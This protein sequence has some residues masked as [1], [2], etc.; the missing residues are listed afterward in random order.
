M[1]P[2]IDIIFLEALQLP[3]G[4]GRDRYL[5]EACGGNAGL[6]RRLEVML[7][8]DPAADAFFDGAVTEAARSAHSTLPGEKPGDEIGRFKLLQVIGEGGFGTVWMAEQSEPVQRRVALKIIRLGMDTREFV[9]RFEQE[10]QALAMMDHPNIARVLDGG[11]TPAGRPY[12]VMELVRGVPVTKFCDVHKLPVSARLEL[13]IE[14][15]HASQH[16]H[17][18]GIIHRDIKPSNVMVTLD[19]GK[20]VPKVIDFG[21]A[22]ATQGKL[23]DKTL[24]TRFEQFIGTP[25][26]MSPEQAGL[27]SYDIDTRC[28]IY[29]LGVLL[30]E[31][32]TGK[33]PFDA[34]SLASAG[35]Q[36][37]CRIIREVEPPKP[38]SRLGTIG[39]K[40]R[41]TLAA[42]RQIEPGKLNRMVEPDLDWIVMKTI[43]K[44]R[45][46]RYE[47]VNGLALD[48]RRFLSSEPVSA[49]PPSATYKFRKFARRNKAALGA[50]A[51]ID[52]VMVAATGVSLWHAGIASVAREEATATALAE[53]A[54]RVE[55]ESIT[56]FLTQVFRSP[57]PSRRG[58]DITISEVL[59]IT[60]KQMDTNLATQPARR[61]HLQTTLGE[62][63][64]GL[65]LP[66]KGIPLHETALAYYVGTF[67]RK[68]PLT[69]GVLNDLANV[70]FDAG[71]REE[72]LKLQ[73]EV[74]ALRREV[75]GPEHVETLKVMN[76][77]ANSF[78]FS[79]RE[80]EAIGLHVE[81][82]ALRRRLFGPEDPSTLSVMNNLAIS[83]MKTGRTKDALRL[84]EELLTIR[85]RILRPAHP[86]VLNAMT[87]LANC[88]AAADRRPEAIALQEEAVPL[89]R[90]VF[91]PEHSRT[92]AAMG[93]LASNYFE[94]GRQDE[95]LQLRKEVLSLCVKNGPE[96]PET[97]IAMGNLATSWS[98]AGNLEEA[99][100]LREE[101][102]KLSRKVNGEEHLDT[103]AAA[104]NLVSS[105]RETA[106]LSEAIVLQG[107]LL[108]FSR[109]VFPPGHVDLKGPLE[110]MAALYEDAGRP[111][112]AAALRREIQE[113]K[114]KYIPPPPL[115]PVASVIVAPDSEWKWLH[116]TNSK[117]PAEAVPDFH[118]TFF[119]PDFDDSAWT[120]GRDSA[121]P[122][123]GFG[124]GISFRGVSIGTPD[125][126]KY[127]R[128]AYFRHRFTTDKTCGNLELRCQRD[129]GIIVYFDGKELLRDNVA[130]GADSWALPAAVT[131]NHGN[132]GVV[133]AY[134]LTGTLEP[135]THTLAISVHNT[136][137]PSSDLRL[138]GVTLVEVE[139]AE[140]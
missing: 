44:D 9:A 95:A 88:Y 24:F 127:R 48:I 41:T 97:L 139:A 140:K 80:V 67:G 99:L 76:N 3:A 132:D 22:K 42:A 4:D 54:A 107:E 70:Y 32:L 36:E 120:A 63:Y 20:A 34:K 73:E 115:K 75:S 72:A 131:M 112:D 30:Y 19:G 33:P 17:Q 47:T 58:R 91:G 101:E 79:G 28:D 121:G 11:A 27:G 100:K 123:G 105:Y 57:D 71:R 110:N 55:S 87:N 37:M 106:R 128:T 46:R 134:P 77:L 43:E 138:G 102:V 13:F 113:F 111:E 119:L 133:Y 74:L 69:L 124:Y 10:R 8:D 25:V 116:P 29:A 78:V 49:S 40:E 35:H 122:D 130:A 38:S 96:L 86:E 52:V 31:L 12:F 68:H 81:L 15:C 82:L 90:K 66:H 109:R 65:G 50:A 85:R 6:R 94:A 45:S 16:A 18:K 129:D 23:T 59:D 117:D 89:C 61:A 2:Q 126:M 93:N 114:S 92:I 83:C 60:V 26:Y 84:M 136:S 125:D 108:E 5:E 137:H 104:K 62:T 56:S 21:I 118:T 53:R 103:I 39:E 1:D 14:V 64:R 51:L 7:A 98:A 135:G